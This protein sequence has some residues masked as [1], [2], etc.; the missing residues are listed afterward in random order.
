M[1]SPL[2]GR[3]EA[4]VHAQ[5]WICRIDD[6]RRLSRPGESHPA[7]KAT[8]AR[9]GQDDDTNSMPARRSAVEVMRFTRACSARR[10]SSML[11]RH[12]RQRND[13]RLSTFAEESQSACRP[14]RALRIRSLAK[15]VMNMIGSTLRACSAFAVKTAHAR[16]WMSRQAR[17]CR[18]GGERKASARQNRQ[19]S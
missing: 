9:E 12:M 5:S 2:A 6:V 10:G 18:P 11:E 17:T 4:R 19:A 1:Q 13:R 8:P 7:A 14:P 3:A 15:A 16:L